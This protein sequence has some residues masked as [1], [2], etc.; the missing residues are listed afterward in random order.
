MIHVEKAVSFL[1]PANGSVHNKLHSTVICLDI[2]VCTPHI[3]FLLNE[4]TAKR[5]TPFVQCD[6]TS[7][8]HSSKNGNLIKF[9]K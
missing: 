1:T 4:V 8:L 9:L 7:V 5:G 3:R 2:L 6:M